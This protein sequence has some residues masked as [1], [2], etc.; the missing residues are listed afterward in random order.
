MVNSIE[1][2]TDSF[3]DLFLPPP[4]YYLKK[5]VLYFSKEVK[6]EPVLP[7]TYQTF[8]K[9]TAVYLKDALPLTLSEVCEEIPRFT[10]SYIYYMAGPFYRYTWRQAERRLKVSERVL[11]SQVTK[12]ASRHF[13]FV[14]TGI[15]YAFF[16]E[17]VQQ[18]VN[19]ESLFLKM[20]EKLQRKKGSKTLLLF[21][22]VFESLNRSLSLAKKAKEELKE[23]SAEEDAMI[24]RLDWYKKQGSLPKSFPDP[25]KEGINRAN[26]VEKL[27]EALSLYVGG[28]S[29]KLVDKIIPESIKK[30]VFA[31]LYY[32]E[33]QAALYVFFQFLMCDC[34]AK[35]VADP[36]LLA[37]STLFGAGLETADYE[38]DG[39]GLGL[40]SR[41]LEVSQK[42]SRA[43]LE[44]RSSGEIIS[45]FE[46]AG[47]KKKPEG[48]QGIE[49]RKK[50]KEA[51][52]V[53]LRKALSETIGKE[54]FASWFIND[55]LSHLFAEKA[56]A[57][58]HDP[59]FRFI[60]LDL[61][62]TIS[63]TIS[64]KKTFAYNN[65][66]TTKT[67]KEVI[68]ALFDFVFE[69]TVY[70][71]LKSSVVSKG[72]KAI[73][74]KVESSIPFGGVP[75]QETLLK[76]L[77]PTLKEITLYARVLGAFRKR[78][79]Y[80]FGDKKFWEFFV[81]EALN[82]FIEDHFKG[83]KVKSVEA[84]GV[85]RN[86][87]IDTLLGLN[88]EGLLK[89]FAQIPVDPTIQEEKNG[90]LLVDPLL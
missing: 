24:A 80:F 30:G 79:V 1:N 44:K 2:S 37:I 12:V 11:Q 45:F 16:S 77:I 56:I 21:Q 83:G 22:A 38:I 67:V 70:T 52:E 29:Q 88:E 60:V 39:F 75:W 8:A 59:S 62:E 40:R 17:R 66:E 42:M 69:G 31:P 7:E 73:F 68:G 47:L 10:F 71:N 33:G 15:C 14:R 64:L 9:V 65:E 54:T 78:G 72:V 82:V 32:L 19:F 4:L 74:F 28:L 87:V 34:A 3:L 18:M 35:I 76:G 43:L 26:L 48:V 41:I 63:E 25:E 58:L 5:C 84:L 53:F 55:N 89:V 27:D 50:A 49:Q 46:E 90:W 86:V 51:L 20:G 85:Q 13:C 57:F 36:H 6:V 61:L 23:F 81:R